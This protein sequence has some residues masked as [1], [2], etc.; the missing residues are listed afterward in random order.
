M[1]RL[2]ADV[3]R[4]HSATVRKASL[5]TESMRQVWELRY[6]AGAQYSAVEWTRDEVVGRNIVATAPQPEP[7]S[8]LK[9][10]KVWCQLLE[11]WLKVLAARECPAQRYSE[12]FVF[13]AEEQRF[14]VVVDFQLTFSFLPSCWDGRLSTLLLQYWT[15]IS[16]SRGIHLP[17][18]CL[19]SAPLPLFV[20]LHQ[21][22]WL[23]GRRHGC[24]GVRS[25]DGGWQGRDV[26][27]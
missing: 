6:Q 20:I 4:R 22:A 17:L 26:D 21:H 24:M 14:I 19:C 1:G 15:L 23:L 11:K 10:C 27:V 13:V 9:E 25:G 5:M 18:P 7:A 8:R 12:A 2:S 3:G 16:T